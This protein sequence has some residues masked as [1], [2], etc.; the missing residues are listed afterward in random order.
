MKKCNA[1]LVSLGLC[2]FQQRVNLETHSIP[3]VTSLQSTPMINM[4]DLSKDLLKQ[5]TSA[6]EDALT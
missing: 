6:T 3:C 4:L 1:A 2:E 5:N